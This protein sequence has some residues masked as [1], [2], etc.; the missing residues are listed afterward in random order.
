MPLEP[1]TFLAV[2][3]IWLVCGI[4]GAAVGTG[5]GKSGLGFALGI[6]LGPIGILITAVVSSG[7][8][9]RQVV[10]YNRGPVVTGSN[11]GDPASIYGGPNSIPSHLTIRRDNQE[12]GT[13]PL[14]DVLEYLQSGHLIPSDMFRNTHGQW[15][16]LSSLT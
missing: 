9:A 3:L 13:W 16:Y 6:L 7:G 1:R 14:A 11:C 8:G 12:I 15:Q 4:I 2:M 10:I 5:A